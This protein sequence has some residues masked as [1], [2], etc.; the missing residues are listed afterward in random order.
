MENLNIVEILQVGVIGLG[1][2]LA[3]MAYR[4]LS[5]EM[6]LKEPRLLLPRD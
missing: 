3:F 4:L 5:Q 1:F 2:L 6:K